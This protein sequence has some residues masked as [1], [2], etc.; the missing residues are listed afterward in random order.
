MKYFIKNFSA[1]VQIFQ[2]L[3]LEE[4]RAKEKEENEKSATLMEE[5]I[6]KQGSCDF[7]SMCTRVYKKGDH[8]NL[9]KGNTCE[10]H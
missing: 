1:V 5:G 7:A 8:Q 3:P 4:D 6:H 10:C 9:I 2:E